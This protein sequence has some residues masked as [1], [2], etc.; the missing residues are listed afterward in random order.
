VKLC[1][2]PGRESSYPRTRVLVKGMREAGIEVLDC[3]SSRKSAVRYVDGFCAFL[4]Y[5]GQS[6]AIVVGFLGQP[7][8]P[9]VRILTKKKI[10]FDA[11][12]S[13][14]QTMVF[15]RRSVPAAGFRAGLCR[16]LDLA[17]CRAADKVFLDTYQ[18]IDYFV[19]TYGM[20]RERFVRLPAGADDSVMYP[21]SAEESG[22]FTV[23]FHG[24]Y[25]RLHGAEHIVEAAA[26][27]PDVR[28][29][30]I[31][32]GRTY[33]ACA[34]RAEELRAGNIT[35]KTPVPYEDLP[36][37]MAG[38]SVCLGIF[39]KTEKAGLV[40]PQKAYEALAMG[41]PLITADTPAAREMLVHEEH[42]LLCRPA[43][44]ED[45]AGAIRRLKDH[46][47][48]RAKI[49]T[50]GHALFRERFAPAAL[51][52]ELLGAAQAVTEDRR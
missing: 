17:S 44:A 40:V 16:W 33:H 4:R 32:Q 35:F 37:Y 11:F 28:F 18:H 9:L 45:L 7:L 27:L 42:A 13:V 43:D 25:Q 34:G 51:G 30:M 8:V 47:E 49:A 23:H 41:K 14:H 6:D 12:L 46:P 5:L 19:R 36:G 38:A 26:L 15:D 48:L 39:G 22:E 24:A 21:R 1:Y 52:R 20:P 2:F 31:G 10:L 29:T 50:N 3:S